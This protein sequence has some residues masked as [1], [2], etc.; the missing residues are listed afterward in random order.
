M[1]VLQRYTISLVRETAKRYEV[2]SKVISSKTSASDLIR[3]V[4]DPMN[5]PG[6]V[7]GL[8]CLDSQNKVIGCHEVGKGTVNQ[9]AVYP[10]DIVMRALLNNAASIIVWHTHPGDSMDPG[11]ADW[12]VTRRLRQICDLMEMPLLDHIIITSDG[13]VSMRESHQWNRS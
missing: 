11:T 2:E 6:E 7:F 13:A 10:R 1:K 4:H 5:Y 8:I 12:S 9:C 3:E